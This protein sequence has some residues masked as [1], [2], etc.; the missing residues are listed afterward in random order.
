MA[1]EATT[2]VQAAGPPTAME[3]AEGLL[4]V[5]SMEGSECAHG[6]GLNDCPGETCER[7]GGGGEIHWN[8]SRNNDPQ[9]VED[10][11]CPDCDGDGVIECRWDEIRPILRRA[12]ALLSE[13]N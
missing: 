13:R 7:C 8:P 4:A 6:Y 11:E 3:L 12:L 5:W 2:Q 9:M 10:A 1:D